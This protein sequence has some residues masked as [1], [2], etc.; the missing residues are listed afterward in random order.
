MHRVVKEIYDGFVKTP[1]TMVA[2][3]CIAAC[4]YMYNDLKHFVDEQKVVLTEQIKNQTKNV[5]LLSQISHRLEE[6]EKMLYNG[7]SYI[8]HN[9]EEKSQ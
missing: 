5:E 4:F 2:F 9:K 6:I 7:K 8:P 3:L 1:V